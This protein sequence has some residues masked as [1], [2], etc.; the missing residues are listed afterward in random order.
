MNCIQLEKKAKIG[1]VFGKS[2]SGFTLVE[3]MIVL[4]I[5]GLI[6]SL[7]IPQINKLFPSSQRVAFISRLNQLV[8][9]AWQ[10]A[11]REQKVHRIYFDFEKNEV[12]VEMASGQKDPKGK[13]IFKPTKPVYFSTVIEWPENLQ[14]RQFFI[15]GTDESQFKRIWFFIVPDGLSQSVI[16]NI[17]D[18]NDL[19]EGSPVRVG[20]VLDPFK[21][22]F[23]I[24]DEF[25]KP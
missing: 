19:V 14:V 6:L 24:Y 13:E 1:S 20:L 25:K 17:Q 22:E 18:E 16:I 8:G 10:S 23:K 9:F 3:T 11:I 2:K 21:P 7:G 15:E 4:G 5:I 12:K